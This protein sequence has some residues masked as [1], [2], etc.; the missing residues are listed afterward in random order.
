MELTWRCV[1]CVSSVLD[2]VKLWNNLG[3]SLCA[4]LSVCYIVATLDKWIKS[5]MGVSAD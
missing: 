1:E 5:K 4:I 2:D 3:F